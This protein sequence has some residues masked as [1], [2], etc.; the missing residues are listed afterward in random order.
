MAD[1]PKTLSQAIRLGATFRPQTRGHIFYDGRS[2]AIGAALEATFGRI[3]DEDIPRLHDRYPGQWAYCQIIEWN[4]G[5]DM[6]REQ[7]AEKLEKMGY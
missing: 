5:D 2:C 6:T 4:D 3:R 7:I 1:K